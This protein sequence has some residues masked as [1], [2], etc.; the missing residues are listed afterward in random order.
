MEAMPELLVKKVPPEKPAGAEAVAVCPTM[1]EDEDRLTEPAGQE[2]ADTVYVTAALWGLLV[3]FVSET[4]MVQEYEPMVEGASTDTV[5]VSKEPAA[6][7]MG[8]MEPELLTP[9]MRHQFWLVWAV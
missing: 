8:P 2:P 7:E 1:M 9:S 6:T 3:A 5:A 4:V